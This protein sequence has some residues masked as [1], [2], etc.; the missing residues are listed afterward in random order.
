MTF[1]VERLAEL[2]KHL[3]HLRKLRPKVAGPA[4]LERDL[5]LHNDVLFS[6]LSVCQLVIDIAGELAARRGDR[7]ESYGEAIRQLVRDPRFDPDMVA[8]LERLPGF[9]NV[10]VHEYVALDMRR[11]VE[12]MDELAPIERFA[13][14]VA[15]I[16]LAE[17]NR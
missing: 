5:S 6:L 3:A 2:R 16:E 10:L 12:A 9:R 17:G 11:V 4:N 7:F 15:A 8:A 1:L 14:T 13:D